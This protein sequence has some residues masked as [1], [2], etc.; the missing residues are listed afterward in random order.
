MTS[1]KAAELAAKLNAQLDPEHGA[2]EI[3]GVAAAADAQPGHL[4]FLGNRKYLPK[5]AVS[6]ASIV[7]VPLD[8]DGELQAVPMRVENPSVAFAGVVSMFALPPPPRFTGIAESA[9]IA[10]T[11]EVDATAAIAH[12]AVVE[13]GAT[14]GAN[15]FIGANSYIGAESKIG[16]DCYI[17]PNVSIRERVTI[18]NRV[19][20]HCGVVIGSDGYGFEF[21]DGRHE[22]IPQIGV[23]QIDDDVEVGANTTIDR[24]R[25]GRT[26]IREGTKIDNLVQIAH[27]VVIGKHCLLVSQAGIAGSTSLG[28]FVTL[29]GQVGI[30][31]HV[32]IGD[33]VIAGAKSGIS[34]DL[35]AGSKVFGYPAEEMQDAKRQIAALHRLPATLSQIRDLKKRLAALEE[36]IASQDT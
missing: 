21:K 29:A 31:G 4:T 24:A 27:N 28:N 22:K 12:H 8:F 2:L 1:I 19:I 6:K 7:L 30:V 34:N 14:I 5:V 9:V 26:W 13:A 33:Q 20:I 18:G 32:E 17:H 11:A 36:T 3:S 15:S 23:V 10:P 35:P 25:F 16:S